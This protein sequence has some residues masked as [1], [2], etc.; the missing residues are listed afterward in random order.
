MNEIFISGYVAAEPMVDTVLC[1]RGQKRYRFEIAASRNS[2]M[3]DTIICLCNENDASCLFEGSRVAIC[4]KIATKYVENHLI[5]FVNAKYIGRYAPYDN[6]MVNV[7]G[8]LCK[9][10]TFRKTPKGKFISDI[11]IASPTGN[12]YEYDYIPSIAWGSVA[13]IAASLQMGDEVN[14]S[15]RL[16]SREYIKKHADGTWERKTVHELSINTLHFI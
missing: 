7:K 5:V 1:E 14:V 3:V 8:I 10:P 11:M 6:N 2:G 12:E 16:Q 9:Q 15:G 13:G 4:G